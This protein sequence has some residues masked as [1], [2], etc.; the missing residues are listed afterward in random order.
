MIQ[1]TIPYSYDP[2]YR[3]GTVKSGSTEEV[4]RKTYPEMHDYMKPFMRKNVSE[5]IDAV[6]KM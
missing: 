5:G 6:K 1:L 4:I 3:F 2:A